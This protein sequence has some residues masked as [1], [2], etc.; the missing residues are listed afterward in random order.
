MGLHEDDTIVRRR[1]AQKLEFLSQ[2]LIQPKPPSDDELRLWFESN[3]DRYKVPELI[4]FTHVF[5]DPDKREQQT[6]EDAEKLKAELIASSK[7]PGKSTTVVGPLGLG[8]HT[9][10]QWQL[11]DRLS[12][13]SDCAET[14]Q[15]QGQQQS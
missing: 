14:D 1:L 12:S 9:T 3:V 4:T 15:T 2:D 7:P 5:L 11:G 6:L 13:A 8:K 10:S